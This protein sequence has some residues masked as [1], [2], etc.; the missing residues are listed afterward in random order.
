MAQMV[1]LLYMI[2]STLLTWPITMTAPYGWCCA[3]FVPGISNE[4]TFAVVS[5]LVILKT[6]CIALPFSTLQSTPQCP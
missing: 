1:P 3:L 2:A 4:C 6:L 5:I